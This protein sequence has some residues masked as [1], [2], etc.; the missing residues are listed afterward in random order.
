MSKK[1]YERL[2]KSSGFSNK[3]F[4]SEF[5]LK[6]L[7]KF[8][9]AEGKGLGKNEDGHKECIQQ[10][11]R[12]VS[13]GLGT[14]KKA[15][16]E[17]QWENWWSDCYNGVAKKLAEKKRTSPSPSPSTDV[18]SDSDSDSDEDEP[19]GGRVT[20]IKSAS[21]MAGKLKRVLRQE[22]PKENQET[23]TTTKATEKNANQKKREREETQ[24]KEKEEEAEPETAPAP[25]KK[26]KKTKSSS[27]EEEETGEEDRP[28]KE[29]RKKN[30]KTKK[31]QRHSS[32][33][34]EGADSQ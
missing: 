29:D 24:K 34:E 2:A 11:R 14:E 16:P 13:A 1:Y 9:W 3:Q 8:G 32:A 25:A 17:A 22:A 5:G 18:P 31:K 4:E 26:A 10:S 28:G 12:E 19:T 23:N 7:Q 33:D 30:K 20:A 15:A 6:I 27:S 21:R